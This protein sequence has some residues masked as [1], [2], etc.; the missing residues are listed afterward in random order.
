MRISLRV[1]ASAALVAL[2][3][4]CDDG[5]TDGPAPQAGVAFVFDPAANLSDP[6]HFYDLPYPS[7]RRLDAEGHPV[8]DGFPNPSAVPMVT[9]L[10]A[11]AKQAKGFPV[12]PVAFL[13]FTGALAPRVADDVVAADPASPILLMDVDADSPDRGKLVPVV[14]QTLEEDPYTP[15]HVLAVAPRPGFILRPKTTYAVVVSTN[16]KDA[17]GAPLA[18]EPVFAAVLGGGGDAALAALYAE[19]R[20]T[21]DA[22]GIARGSVAAATVFTTGNVVAETADLGDGVKAKYD[23]TIDALTLDPMEV[24][25]ELCVLRGSVSLPQ[26]QEGTPPFNTEGLFAFDAS[27]APIEQRKETAPVAIVVPR[28]TMPDAGFPMALNI[29]GSGGDSIEMVRYDDSFGKVYGPAFPY[30]TKGIAMAGFAMPVNPERLPGA[31]STAYININNLA[32]LRDTFRQGV[33]EGRLFVE[34]LTKLSIPASALSGC[35]GVVLPAGQTAV[36]FDPTKLLVTGWSMGG[37]YTNLIGATEPLLRAAVPT[38]AGGH[39]THFILETP[40]RN[41]VIPGFLKLLLGTPSDLTF[42]HPVLSIGAAALEPADPIVYMP[43]LARDP[44]PGHPVRPVYEPTSIG[45]SF[46]PT[47]TYDAV[48]LAYGHEETGEI[49][50][51]TMQE[52]LALAGRSGIVPTPVTDNLSS[53]GGAAYTGV[54]VQ[55]E[56]DGP[57]DPH[58]IYSHRDD[59]KRQYSCFFDTFLRTGKAT[60]VAPTTDWKSACP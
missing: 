25:P 37:M 57:Y 11:S 20:E 3:A 41:G 55:S 13:R 38:G 21:L 22:K 26:F 7:D 52:A 9:G 14:T 27:G 8:L 51:P 1:A 54:V 24:Y 56:A 36:K 46:F 59:V 2:A 16:A 15:P 44:L 35:P 12:I 48:A 43:R 19:L 34:A 17:S 40:L 4:A 45:D 49:V 60:V 6:A 18:V 23:V 28:T 58:A 5:G 53:D 32:A 39:W 29:H 31:E 42:L 10:A 47:P 30:A 33:M 50:W